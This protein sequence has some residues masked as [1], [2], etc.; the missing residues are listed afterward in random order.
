[1]QF[2]DGDLKFMCLDGNEWVEIEDD[3]IDE[4]C[5]EDHGEDDVEMSMTE[6]A[7]DD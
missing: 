7:I 2:I 3:Y 6:L 5:F 1:V 4:E